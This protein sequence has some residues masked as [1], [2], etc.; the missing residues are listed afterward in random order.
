MILNIVYQQSQNE[1]WQ[2]QGESVDA[3]TSTANIGAVEEGVL[4]CI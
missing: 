2:G 4:I 1:N 3:S